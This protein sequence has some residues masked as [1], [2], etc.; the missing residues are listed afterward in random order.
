MGVPGLG[1][2]FI[3]TIEFFF[4]LQQ[5]KE[6]HCIAQ[7]WL[8]QCRKISKEKAQKRKKLRNVNSLP[9]TY[10]PPCKK[11]R[12]PFFSHISQKA[13]QFWANLLAFSFLNLSHS[14]RVTFL[15]IYRW[16]NSERNQI[17]YFLLE[18]SDPDVWWWVK[19]AVK[20]YEVIWPFGCLEDS[21]RSLFFQNFPRSFF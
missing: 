16:F 2:Q 4:R 17:R 20:A 7:S 10:V 14:Q 9:Y 1:E 18:V 6:I 21:G 13:L 5:W 8:E 3:R 11:D 19:E 15:M 12:F